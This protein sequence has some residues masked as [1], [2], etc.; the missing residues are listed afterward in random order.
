SYLQRLTALGIRMDLGAVRAALEA[1]DHPESF[2]PALL[3]AGTNGKGSVAAMAAAILA[4]AGYSVGLYTSPH[5]VDVRERIRVDGEMITQRDLASAIGEI[6]RWLDEP[7]TYFEF[8]TVLAGFH[9]RKKKIDIAVIEVGMGGRLDAT[10]VFEAPVAVI[11]NV[12]RDHQEYL[13]KRLRDIAT[14][15]AAIIPAGGICVTAVRPSGARQAIEDMARERGT[16]LWRLG[17]EIKIR[18]RRDGTFSYR[19]EG[20]YRHALPCNLKGGHQRQNAALAVAAV[21]AMADRGIIVSDEA[22]RRGLAGVHWE[23]RLE[24]LHRDPVLLIDG[25]HNPAGIRVLCRALREEFS[26]RRLIVVFGVLRDKHYREMAERMVSVASMMI[27]TCPESERSLPPTEL[28]PF[29]GGATREVETITSP[30]AALRRAFAVAHA[31]DLILVTGS[32]YLVGEI[33][34]TF[35]SLRTMI[36]PRGK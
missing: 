20:R 29:T 25:A 4:A 14:E 19:C 11:T 34:K 1:L 12:A 16:A 15:K 2:Y 31:E 8:L 26:F 5:L 21:E 22:I 30:V 36:A 17:K 32:L 18:R 10:R 13:G 24:V 35:P 28:L 23:G 3:I 33:K 27:L 7:L 9:F 6:D